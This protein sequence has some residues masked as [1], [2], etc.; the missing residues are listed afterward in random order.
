MLMMLMRVLMILGGLLKFNQVLYQN[1]CFLNVIFIKSL[2][3][4][5]ILLFSN[6]FF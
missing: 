4:L 5:Q 6:Q 3:F 1:I 2:L